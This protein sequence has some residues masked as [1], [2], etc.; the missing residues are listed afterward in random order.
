MA[1][2]WHT[3]RS[4]WYLD[5][6]NVVEVAP[7]ID[8][9]T[10]A[11]T[12]YIFSDTD[13][14]EVMNEAI[15]LA[16]GWVPVIG[17]EWR[18]IVVIMNPHVYP[19]RGDAMT[20]TEAREWAN[21]QYESL[22]A[23]EWCGTREGVEQWTSEYGEPLWACGQYHADNVIEKWEVED[24]REQVDRVRE[25]VSAMSPGCEGAWVPVAPPN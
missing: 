14:R 3:G 7:D 12:G 18:P 21:K 4:E 15:T 5:G 25:W 23:C 19:A 8:C 16:E 13:P 10:A 9:L 1:T 11:I 6:G 17:E 2:E 24:Y 22:P 20:P